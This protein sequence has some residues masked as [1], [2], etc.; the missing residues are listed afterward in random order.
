MTRPLLRLL[1]VLSL[2]ALVAPVAD[3]VAAPLVLP[4][5]ADGVLGLAS[6]GNRAYAITGSTS[7]ARPFTLVRISGRKARSLGRFGVP[8][9]LFP[10]VAAAGGRVVVSW[11]RPAGAGVILES[12]TSQG[13]GLGSKRTLGG[14]TGPGRLAL[15]GTRPLLAVPDRQGDA[16]VLDRGAIAGLT[17]TAPEERHLPLDL[18]LDG[19]RPVVLDLV[20]TRDASRLQVVGEGVPRAALVTAPRL[21]FLEGTLAVDAGRTSVAY[22][23]S[24]RAVLATPAAGGWERRVLPGPGGGKGAPAV[25]R[26]GGRTLVI[27]SQR[28]GGA[29]EL[30]VATLAGTGATRVRRLTR[31]P[32]DDALPFAAAAPGGGAFVGWSRSARGGR[33]ASALVERI[34]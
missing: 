1:L 26:T 9:G 16:A 18:A 10:D 27:Y 31:D 30:Y 3:A 2:G 34:R 11:A 33:P 6:S 15:D 21:R 12:A 4:G 32:A 25:V 29:G 20:Q 13:G 28:A 14:A 5:G 17:A 19:G 22:L 23:A 24:G 8:E 7:A